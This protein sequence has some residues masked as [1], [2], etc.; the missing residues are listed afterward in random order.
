MLFTTMGLFCTVTGKK[1]FLYQGKE[2]PKNN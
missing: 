2:M 1:L